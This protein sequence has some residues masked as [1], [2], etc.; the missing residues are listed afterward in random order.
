MNEKLDE[1]RLWSKINILSDDKCWEW[2][3]A[4]TTAGYGVIRINYEL[5]YAHRLAWMLKNKAEIPKK[6]V[7]CHRCDNPSCCNPNH[8]FLG[9]Q[10]DNIRDAAKKDRMPKG[11]VHHM[12]SISKDDVRHIRYLG[13]TN[14]SKKKIGEKFGISRQAVTDILCKRTWGHIDPEWEPPAKKSKGA[15]HPNAK[16]TEEDIRSIRRLTKSMSIRAI[17]RKFNVSRGTITPIIKGETWKH[18]T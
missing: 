16:L 3:G 13:Y 12:S 15:A 10:A 5:N 9:T 11:E 14:M 4:K 1:R 8:L 2:Q 17:A 7:I 18:V 6:G